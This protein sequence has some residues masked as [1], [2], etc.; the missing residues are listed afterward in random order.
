[1]QIFP[2]WMLEVFTIIHLYEAWLATL[3]IFVWHLY[4]VVFSPDIYPLN[5]SMV[6]GRM[7]EAEMEKEHGRELARLR[8]ESL[9][10]GEKYVLAL[11]TVRFLHSFADPEP[12]HKFRLI[13]S[14]GT[15]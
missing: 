9:C 13:V 6:D 5:M 3:A 2:F 14:A 4:S 1:M 11:L 15:A 10:P 7:S 8:A 12:A